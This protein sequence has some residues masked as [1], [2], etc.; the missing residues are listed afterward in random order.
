MEL[1]QLQ[2]ELQNKYRKRVRIITDIELHVAML[3]ALLFSLASNK[4]QLMEILDVQ[5]HVIEYCKLWCT[6]KYK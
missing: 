1:S 6:C 4:N 2:G 5:L 3:D